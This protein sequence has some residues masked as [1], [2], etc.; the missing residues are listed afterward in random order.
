MIRSDF[1]VLGS[2]IA[3]LNFALQASGHGSVSIATK[4]DAIE[5]NTNFAQGGVAAV[6]SKTD[7]FRLHIEDTLKAGDGL[8]NEEAV[9]IMVKNAPE[10][11]ERLISLGAGFD[12]KGGGLDL[13]REA[14]H[15]RKRIVHSG[16]MTGAEVEKAL[17]EAARRKRNVRMFEKHHAF[18]LIIKNRRC[19]GA[20]VLDETNSKVVDFFAKAVAIATGGLCQVYENT[21]NPAIATGDGVAMGFRAGCEVEDIEFIQ[22]HPTALRRKGK[23]F[24]LISEAVRGEGGVLKNAKG[25]RFVDELAFRDEVARAIFREMRNGKV[26]LDI[27]HK[28]AGFLKKRFPGI[29]ATCLENGIDITRDAIPVEPVAHYSCGGIKTDTEGRTDVPGLFAFGEAACTGVHGANRLASNSLLESLV[30][31][32]RAVAAAEAFAKGKAVDYTNTPQ[33]KITEARPFEIITALKSVMWKKAGI[34]RNGEDLKGALEKINGL[35][36]RLGGAAPG[37]NAEVIEAKNMLLV[38]KLI[39]QAALAR[40]ESRGGH[41]RED[42]PAKAKEWERHIVLNERKVGGKNT[43]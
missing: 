19:I 33:M 37:I 2:G 20:R 12:R 39:V 11:I 32:S 13:G 38:S 17:V 14:G 27:S 35:G 22:F 29:Y 42:Y 41:Y 4:K 34:S 40:Q 23:P 31:S 43:G 1:L 10:E 7:D 36:K 25:K 30:F 16:D 18:E 28:E 6:F 3:G 21:S 8:C 24:F 26:Y 15:S 9:K 5:S